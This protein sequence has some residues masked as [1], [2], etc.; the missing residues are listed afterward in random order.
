MSLILLNLAGGTSVDDLK[1]LN[2]DSGFCEV[3]CKTELY[4]LKCKERWEQERRWR[5]EKKRFVPSPSAMFRYLSGFHDADQEKAREASVTKAF[6]PVAND[7]L[8]GLVKVNTDLRVTFRL[9]EALNSVHP[10]KTATLDMDA[11]LVETDKKDALY[12]Y[13]GFKSYQ[14]LNTWWAEQGIIVH[15]EFRDGNVPAGGH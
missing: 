2:A 3:L 4:G 7:Y 10:Q 12:C 6:I 8:Q 9:C 13:K 1:I 15:I 14:P 11:T 5:K